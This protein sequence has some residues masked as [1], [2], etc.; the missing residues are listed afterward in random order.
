MNDDGLT[1]SGHRR[2]PSIQQRATEQLRA[3]AGPHRFRVAFDAEGFPVIPGRYGQI[4]WF[5]GTELA[6]YTGRPRLFARLWAI[7]GVRRHQTG[8]IEMRAVFATGALQPVARVI[9]ARR[10][11]TLSAEE[12]RRRG[13]NPPDRAS[14]ALPVALRLGPQ[15]GHRAQTSPALPEVRCPTVSPRPRHRAQRAIP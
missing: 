13:F 4:E 5:D 11:R 15:R 14:G 1:A 10:R 3:L 7:L 9:K 8:D 2:Q 12:A 6:V